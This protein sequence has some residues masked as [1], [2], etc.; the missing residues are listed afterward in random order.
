[1]YVRADPDPVS[2]PCDGPDTTVNVN[3]SPSMSLPVNVIPFAVS[4]GVDT[5]WPFATG[6]SFNGVT[7]MFTVA[8]GE[9][10]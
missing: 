4:S 9:S 6:A 8:V 2:P 1:M 10:T 7:S 5:D 3:P